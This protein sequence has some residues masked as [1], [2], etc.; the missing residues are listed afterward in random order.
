MPLAAGPNP[1]VIMARGAAA[2][3]NGVGWLG[4]AIRAELN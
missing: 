1:S 3:G 4:V 2:R